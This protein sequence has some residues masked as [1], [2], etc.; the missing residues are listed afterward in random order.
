MRIGEHMSEPTRPITRRTMSTVLLAPAALLVAGGGAGAAPRRAPVPVAEPVAPAVAPGPDFAA[1]ERR[2]GARVGVFAQDTGTGRTI[3]HRADEAFPMCSTFK[4]YAVAAVLRAH[5]LASGFPEHT[6][7]IA[8][9]EVVPN[10]PIT[11][12]R[13][14]GGMTVSELCRAAIT[15]SDNTAAN[16]LFDIVGGPPGLTAFARSIGDRVTRSDRVEPDLSSGV[17]GD[18]RDTTSPAAIGAGYRDIVL[19][20]VLRA[21]ERAL[22]TEWLLANVT[23]DH[24]IRAGLPG[25]WRTADKTGT[26]GYGT[27]NDIAVTWPA[28]GAPLVLAVL[29]TGH[30][31]DAPTHEALIAEIARLASDALTGG[32]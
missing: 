16:K 4:T 9:D 1:L 8:P 5:P 7:A 26:G 25:T 20:G 6:I 3:A 2:F 10:S 12:P 24:R 31:R 23:G 15:H 22:L 30:A 32:R 19:G 21:P 27:A 14:G 11:G 29:T 17:P 28:T 13:A 18:P